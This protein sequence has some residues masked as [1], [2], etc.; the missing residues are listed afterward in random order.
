MRHGVYPLCMCVCV[1]KQWLCDT[2]WQQYSVHTVVHPCC[3]S[4]SRVVLAD[5]PVSCTATTATSPTTQIR[6]TERC[7]CKSSSRTSK[8]QRLWT[9]LE[10]QRV[11]YQWCGLRPSVSIRTRP[12]WD[13]TNRSWSWASHR[14]IAKTALAYVVRVQMKGCG[15]CFQADGPVQANHHLLK[16]ARLTRATS[17]PAG[18][19]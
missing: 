14:T 6:P 11:T 5:R 19:R 10:F 17:P 2:R 12:V 9:I 8:S 4:R 18:R 7:F 1:D 3:T 16:V 13:Q 15:K